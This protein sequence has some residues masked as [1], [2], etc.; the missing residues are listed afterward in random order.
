MVQP[1]L[2]QNPFTAFLNRYANDWVLLVQEVL[3]GDPDDVQ[4]SVLRDVQNGVR[5]VAIRSGHGVGKTTVLAWCAICHLLTRFP[6]KTICTAPTK[7]QLFDALSSEIKA[8]L[9]KLPKAIADFIEVKVERIEHKSAPHESFIAFNTSR[10]ETPEAMAGVH[11]A[12]VLL[13]PDEAS[14]IPQQVFEAAIGSMSGHNATTLLAGNPVRT[15]GLFFNVFNKPEVSAMWKKYHISC[16]GHPRVTPDMVAQVVAE[17]GIDSNAYRVRVLGEFPLGDDDT[18]IPRELAMQAYERQ[19]KVDPLDPTRRLGVR[20]LLV[21]PIWGLD[22]A[23]GGKDRTALAK[24]RGN[25]QMAP[26]D[27]R[28]YNDTMVIV[29]W[30]KTQWMET[31]EMDRPSDIYIDAIGLGAGVVDRLRELGLPAVG[32]N[33]GE[34]PAL[35]GE[36]YGLVRDELWFK[37]KDW[38]AAKDCSLCDLDLIEELVIPRFKYKSSGKKVVE[39]KDDMKKRGFKSPNRADAWNLTLAGDAVSAAGGQSGAAWARTPWNQPLTRNV[40]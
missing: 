30:V 24:R 27:I 12:N 17:Y 15:A 37:S 23:R 32:I 29:G 16:I 28:H 22:C 19:D 21:R 26:I 31:R 8:W 7:G 35:D 36:K 5:R 38:L 14:G 4:K 13:I 3:G 2:Q 9:G 10:A 40:M 20:P 18:V 34:T 6:Q 39:S 33:V 11:S 25:V 1:P